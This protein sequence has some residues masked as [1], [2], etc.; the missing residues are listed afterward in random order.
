MMIGFA[1]KILRNRKKYTPEQI[2]EANEVVEL[3]N[4]LRL[5]PKCKTRIISYNQYKLGGCFPCNQWKYQVN[6]F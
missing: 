1:H 5:C 3:A 4:S 2:A 6:K